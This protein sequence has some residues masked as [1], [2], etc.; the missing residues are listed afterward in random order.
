MPPDSAGR[1]GDE[2]GHDPTPSLNPPHGVSADGEDARGGRG[3]GESAM[4]AP[5]P[6]G[7]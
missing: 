5:S 7:A 6:A 3:Q 2:N 4:E 1:P